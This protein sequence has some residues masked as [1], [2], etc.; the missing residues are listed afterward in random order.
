MSSL[1][2]IGIATGFVPDR[3]SVYIGNDLTQYEFYIA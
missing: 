3:P 1:N 2:R